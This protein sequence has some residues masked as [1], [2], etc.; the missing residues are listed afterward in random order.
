MIWRGPGKNLI[1][2]DVTEAAELDDFDPYLG[3]EGCRRHFGSSGR[4]LQVSF[5]ASTQR[6]R[7][8]ATNSPTMRRVYARVFDRLG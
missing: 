3:R 8:E 6:S 4:E 7:S 5:V 2:V 1:V